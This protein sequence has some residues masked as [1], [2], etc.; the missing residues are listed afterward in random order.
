M[1]KLLEK[2][3]FTPCSGLYKQMQLYNV[4]QEFVQGNLQHGDQREVTFTNTCLSS[5]ENYLWDL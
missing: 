3:N 5:I 1:Y 4:M 2:Q